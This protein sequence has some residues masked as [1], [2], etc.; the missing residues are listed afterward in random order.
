MNQ[1]V[2]GINPIQNIIDYAP[3]RIKTVLVRE[4]FKNTRVQ[5]L[6]QLIQTH[7]I[8]VQ[9]V[10]QNTINKKI[11]GSVHQGIMAFIQPQKKLQEEDLF[12]IISKCS[13]PFLLILDGITDPHNL[14]A[15]IRSAYAA[16]VHAVLLPKHHS[17]TLNPTVQ[18]VSSG[19]SNHIPLIYIT[20]L[21]RTIRILKQKNIWIIGTTNKSNRTLYQSNMKRPISLV[22]GAEHKGIR[23][24]THQNCDE[25]VCIPMYGYISSLNASVATG[26]CLYEA[27]RQRTLIKIE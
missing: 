16:G 20:N 7:G 6:I 8:S 1:I 10:H 13:N 24:L 27:V 19:A 2:Y 4:G 11:I 25:I 22:V 21:A 23:H 3:Q 26:I 14:G 17:A 18:K 12:N 15:C 9:F 5:N